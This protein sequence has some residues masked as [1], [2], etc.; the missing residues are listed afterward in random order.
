MLFIIVIS[1]QYVGESWR[2]LES[3]ADAGGL[4]GVYLLKTTI[5]VMASLMLLQGLANLL[6]AIH[7]LQ[8]KTGGS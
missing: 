1:W 3:S 6:R 4:P 2:V 8:N 7:T 5:I